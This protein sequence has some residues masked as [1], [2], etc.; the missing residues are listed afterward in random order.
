MDEGPAAAATPIDPSRL[1][2]LYGPLAEELGAELLDAFR[3]DARVFADRLDDPMALSDLDA[4]AVT[5][6]TIKGS[7]GA[8]A[9]PRLYEVAMRLEKAARAGNASQAESANGE[10][11]RELSRF[12]DLTFDQVWA[13]GP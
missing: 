12:F 2:E 5:A 9:A 7:A 1:A 6:H 10:V 13:P 11:R 4:L 3:S 8:L